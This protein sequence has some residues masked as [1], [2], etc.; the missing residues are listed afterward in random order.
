[1]IAAVLRKRRPKPH[2][3]W[4]LDE[5]HLKIEWRLVYVWR[6]VDAEVLVQSKRNEAAVIDNLRSYHAL[7][8]ILALGTGFIAADGP[9][10]GRRA[11]LVEDNDRLS[12]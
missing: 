1:M 4:H 2:P 3:N 6:A 11:R 10:I 12:A 8:E 5:V 7:R 9:T